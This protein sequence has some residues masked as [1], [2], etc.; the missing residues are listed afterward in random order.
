MAKKGKAEGMVGAPA[1]MRP[2][3]VVFTVT[4][5][6]PL[7]QNNPANFIGVDQGSGITT[8]RKKYDDKEEAQLRLYIDGDTFYHP[9]NAFTKAALRAVAGKKFGKMFAT[10][11][12]KGAVFITEPGVTILDGKGKPARKYEIDRQPVVVNK[13]RVLRCRPKWMPWKMR[14]ALEVD[15]ALLSAEQVVEALSLAGRIIG[16]GDFRPEKSGAFGRFSV[17][18]G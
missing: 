15:M 2:E 10:T 12:I 14:L 11:M 6:S 13:A 8:G 1:T 4:G 18:L 3:I 17:E 16:I 9:A 5:L 7:L